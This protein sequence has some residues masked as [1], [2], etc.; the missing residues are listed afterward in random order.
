MRKRQEMM[1]NCGLQTDPSW[2]RVLHRWRAVCSSETVSGDLFPCYRPGKGRTLSLLHRASQ[3]GWATRGQQKC[4]GNWDTERAAWGCEGGEEGHGSSRL[5]LWQLLLPSEPGF[6]GLPTHLWP[7]LQELG[8]GGSTCTNWLFFIP[9]TSVSRILFGA[10]CPKMSIKSWRQNKW[11][12]ASSPQIFEEYCISCLFSTV[13]GLHVVAACTVTP[14]PGGWVQCLFRA[15]GLLW[16]SHLTVM[17][18]LTIISSCWEFSFLHKLWLWGRKLKLPDLCKAC[19]LGTA[20]DHHLP[21][22]S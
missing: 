16:R 1:P 18:N 10:M 12:A 17:G 2:H 7:F 4:S 8:L 22:S 15:S 5:R 9:L 11:R 13:F 14:A 19:L 20:D 6:T 21:S 3:S